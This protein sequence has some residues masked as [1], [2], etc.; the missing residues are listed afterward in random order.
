MYNILE[1][2]LKIKSLMW[3]QFI[4]YACVALIPTAVDFSLLYF[5]TEFVGVY[6]MSSLTI[7]FIAGLS[8]S[9]VAQKNLTFK[10]GSKKYASQFSVFCGISCAGLAINAIIVFCVVEFFG[11]WYIFGKIIAT[12]IVFVWNFLAHKYIT[13]FE[14]N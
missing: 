7:A 13:F 5:L 4:V 12:G 14:M 3:R 10:N 9:Y 8:V 2:K 1:N 6:Y 11:L